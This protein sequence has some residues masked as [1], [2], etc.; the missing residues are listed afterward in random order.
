MF[1]TLSAWFRRNAYGVFTRRVLIAIGLAAVSV[2]LSFLPYDTILQAIW[3]IVSTLFMASLVLRER[4]NESDDAR[5]RR[6]F[7]S[8]FLFLKENDPEALTTV[9]AENIRP[10]VLTWFHDEFKIPIHEVDRIDALDSL[11]RNGDDPGQLIFRTGIELGKWLNQ[12]E[13]EDDKVKNLSNRLEAFV[14]QNTALLGE[15]VAPGAFLRHIRHGE[16]RPVGVH[17]FHEASRLLLTIEHY[18]KS[19]DRTSLALSAKAS[20]FANDAN[21]WTEFHRRVHEEFKCFQPAHGG[22]GPQKPTIPFFVGAI[23]ESLVFSNDQLTAKLVGLL[24]LVAVSN[25]STDKDMPRPNGESKR[26]NDAT[27]TNSSQPEAADNQ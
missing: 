15:E 23:E 7:E 18:G 4:L 21:L 20:L 10:R 19:E 22:S 6:L 1:R 14:Q 12:S 11:A 25:E 9:F 5:Y 24:D 27:E 17:M 2:L 13:P 3:V 8:R 16:A 26:P